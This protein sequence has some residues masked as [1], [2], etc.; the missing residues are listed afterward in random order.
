MKRAFWALAGVL[1]VAGVFARYAG[2]ERVSIDMQAFLL[3]WYDEMAEDGFAAL[4]QP[5]SNYTP[6]YLY[7]LGLATLTQAVLPSVTA[8]KLI[9]ILF[10]VFSAF[11]VYRIVQLR[12]PDGPMPL[13]GAAVFFLLPTVVLNS[14]VW[15]QADAIYTA[16]LLTCLY[17]LIKGRALAAIIFFA[18][19]LS[20]KAQAVFL[21]PFLLLLAAR[22]RIS[23]F[24]FGSVPVV[25]ILMM[26]P[27][28]IAGRSLVDVLGIYANQANAYRYLSLNAPN[29]YVFVPN[30]LYESAVLVGIF[31]T[32]VVVAAWVAIYAYKLREFSPESILL[33]A[34]ASAAIVPYFLPKMHERYFYPAE[35]LVLL[36]AILVPRVWLIALG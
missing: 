26:V 36:T 31:I 19:S 10:D 23:W 34:S 33:S 35:V 30:Y 18:V 8:I 14:S 16:F 5:F 20:F 1:L 15:G 2:L 21:A 4:Q 7:L 6:P 27:A 24:L 29:L 32:F 11:L 28:M 12:R 3:A 25:Y 22:K 17:C 13:I 9:S